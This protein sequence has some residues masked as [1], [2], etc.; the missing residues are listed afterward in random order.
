MAKWGSALVASRQFSSVTPKCS[1]I[2]S[3]R[4]QPGVNATAV[5]ACAASSCDQAKASRFTDHLARS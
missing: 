3:E 5:A 4:S 1:S 2:I